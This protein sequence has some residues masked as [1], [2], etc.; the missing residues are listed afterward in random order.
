MPSALRASA[1]ASGVSRP[2]P[3]AVATKVPIK[4]ASSVGQSRRIS[5]IERRPEPALPD[6][7]EQRRDDDQRG[8]F[9]G[10]HDQA[11][12]ADRDGRQAL[13]EHAFDE[14]GEHE[15]EAPRRRG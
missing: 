5:G 1:A 2:K 14:A 12:Q 9:A 10:R 11:E 7:G 8:R 4:L 3:S 15:G 6:V 13:A